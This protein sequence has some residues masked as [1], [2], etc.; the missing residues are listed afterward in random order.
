MRKVKLNLA[1]VGGCIK[2]I[3]VADTDKPFHSESGLEGILT[4]FALAMAV[5]VAMFSAF[6]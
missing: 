3:G 6:S 4:K 5:A 1:F 2:C